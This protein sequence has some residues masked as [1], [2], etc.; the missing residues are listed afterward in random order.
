MRK[1][2][3]LL[4]ILLCLFLAGCNNEFAKQEYDSAEKI[5][6]E[7][8]RYAKEMSVFNPIEG[9]YSLTVSKFDG[10]ETLWTKNLK[11]AQDVEIDFLF[12]LSA[13]QAKLVHVD[14]D[15]N[16]TTVLECSPETSAEELVTKTVSLKSG[17]NRLKIVGYDCEEVELQMLFEEP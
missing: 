13:G 14:A 7:G 12:S 11:E 2:K 16:V 15:G 5:A 6:Q 3:G 9:G 1:F 10:R 8:D 4:L 17:K